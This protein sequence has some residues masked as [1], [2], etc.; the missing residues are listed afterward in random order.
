VLARVPNGVLLYGGE[1]EIAEAQY[2]ET[3]FLGSA[4]SAWVN[5]AQR[6]PETNGM[7][8]AWYGNDAY[9]Y[10]GSLRGGGVLA[11]VFQRFGAERTWSVIPTPPANPERRSDCSLV[12][13]A[14]GQ[15]FLAG[16]RGPG[17]AKSNWYRFDVAASLWT[18]ISLRP[19]DAL[20]D[21]PG[22][23]LGAAAFY[24]SIDGAVTIYGGERRDLDIVDSRTWRLRT[25]GDACGTCADG[26]TC[27]DGACCEATACG[28]CE[29]CAMPGHRG[30]CAARGVALSAPGC[31]AEDG[32][33]CN[34]D[35]RCR[36][37]EGATCTE[38]SQCASGSCAAGV[39]CPAEGCA[40][41]CSDDHTQKNEDGTTTSCGT[42]ACTGTAC[43]VQC[44]TVDDCSDGND[45]S[46][47]K[48][49]V[50]ANASAQSEDAGCSCN[51][52]GRRGSVS[53]F[54]LALVALAWMRR[55]AT[56]RSARPAPWR[57]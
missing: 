56:A 39:C 44:S 57:A 52:P 10:G 27:V 29:S 17:E 2:P 4:S 54:G 41:R 33:A 47:S 1:D 19:Y 24:D 28:P 51:V 32:L 12:G 50:P 3:W 14:R 23:L 38:A 8:A 30:V 26:L 40:E 11:T 36:A 21:S 5:L 15:L 46:T 16:G 13:D 55:R 45:C 53:A 43:L 22:R 7:C 9:L 20:G 48:Q 35:G 18:P 25:V 31:T 37:R 6:I 42:Y 49:C 34:V